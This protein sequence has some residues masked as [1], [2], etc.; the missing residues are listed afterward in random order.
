MINVAGMDGSR[1]L[2]VGAGLAGLMTALHVA[3]EPVIVV[4]KEPLASGVASAWAQG[5]I[6]AA[7]GPDDH[8]ALHAADTASA[9]AGLCD[10]VVVKRV[11]ASAEQTIARLASFGAAFD[12][13]AAGKWLLGLE[14]AHERRRIVHARG[15]GTGREIVRALCEAAARTPSITILEGVEVERLLIEDGAIAGVMAHTSS[16]P[17]VIP[18][19]RVV[20]ATG[21]IGGLYRVTSNPP[22]A[23]GRGLALAARAGALLADLEFVQFHPTALDVAVDPAPLVSEAVRGEGVPLIDEAG[24][25]FMLGYEYRE[26]EPRDVVARE[27]WRQLARGRRVFLDATAVLG[28]RFTDRFPAIHAQCLAVGIDPAKTPIPVQPAAHYHMGG[29]AVDEEGRTTVEGLWACGEVACTGLHGA[30]RLAGNSL[31]EAAACA[32]WVAESVSGTNPKRATGLRGRPVPRPQGVGPVRSILSDH[33]GLM[34]DRAGLEQ[35]VTQLSRLTVSEKSVEDAALVGLMI[36]SA[37][38]DRTESRGSHFR[39]DF[40][41]QAPRLQRSR[42]RLDSDGMPEV[43]TGVAAALAGA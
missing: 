8:P 12:R 21:G 23:T 26:L 42:V 33:V 30:N 1:P 11:T 19:T 2:I 32:V 10:P 9:G 7:L 14:A 41:E 5:G 38:L 18:S 4:A 13:D 15:D 3:P 36:A 17:L 22:G 27:V 43:L 39:V 40:P 34:R 37:A 35:A 24:R 29:I 25:R 31:L 6:A 20:L 16:G 28:S